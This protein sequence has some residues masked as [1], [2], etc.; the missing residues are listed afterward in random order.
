[1]FTSQGGAIKIRRLKQF[2]RDKILETAKL[3]SKNATTAFG[4]MINLQVIP[5]MNSIN[6]KPID[7]LFRIAEDDIVVISDISGDLAGTMIASF[8]ADEGMK[9]LNKMLGRDISLIKDLENEETDALKE[10]I[11]VVAG[12]FLSE[13]GNQTGFSC[14]PEIPNFEG[15]FKEVE[16]IMVEQLKA[17]NEYI[18]LINSS[19]NVIDLKADA[20]FYILFD[21]DSLNMIL[22]KL[23][24][25]LIDDPFEDI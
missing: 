8:K 23:S 7:D 22:N 5:N 3:C 11:N 24:K 19:M 4:M 12:A 17:I 21:N 15:R 13:F 1:M 16:K 6:T 9:I 18:L 2:L 20:V 14:M 25:G 10:Y